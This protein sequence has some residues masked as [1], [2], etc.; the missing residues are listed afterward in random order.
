MFEEKKKT[1]DELK[2]NNMMEVLNKMLELEKERHKVSPVK[3]NS[4]LGRW[5]SSSNVCWFTMLQVSEDR[6][7]F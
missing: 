7:L 1:V 6:P 2:E 5:D 4:V 3:E